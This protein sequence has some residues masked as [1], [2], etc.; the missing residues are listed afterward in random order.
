VE[1]LFRS[2]D[3]L[4][5]VPQGVIQVE[6]QCAYVI[7]FTEEAAA[8]EGCLP[9]LIISLRAKAVAGSVVPM[10]GHRAQSRRIER[11]GALHAGYGF[12]CAGRGGKLE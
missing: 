9:A 5:V 2:H 12:P 7:H 3:D 4:A 11:A 6:C 8:G 1:R 10:I